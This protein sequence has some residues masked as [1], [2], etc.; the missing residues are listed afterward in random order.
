MFK[1]KQRPGQKMTNFNNYS[2]KSNKMD[3][4]IVIKSKFMNMLFK[5]ENIS[6]RKAH[7]FK[8]NVYIIDKEKHIISFMKKEKKKH[9]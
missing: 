1:Q 4:L 8:K 9:I 6:P 7:A 5:E 3:R 2:L